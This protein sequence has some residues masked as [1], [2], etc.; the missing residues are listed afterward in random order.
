[1]QYISPAWILDV[2]KKEK[3]KKKPIVD[4]GGNYKYLNMEYTLDNILVPMLNILD[5]AM[6]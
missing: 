1:M 6:I 2:K 3:K 5:V 4:K